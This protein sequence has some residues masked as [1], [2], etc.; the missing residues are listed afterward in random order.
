MQTLGDSSASTCFPA[1]TPIHMN[2]TQTRCP[3]APR[4]VVPVVVRVVVGVVKD[5]PSRIG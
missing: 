3:A 5:A 1:Q 2:T 4:T